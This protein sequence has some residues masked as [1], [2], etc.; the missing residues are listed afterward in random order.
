[1]ITLEM[2]ISSSIGLAHT[3]VGDLE[4]ATVLQLMDV[5]RE[6]PKTRYVT[7]PHALPCPYLDSLWIGSRHRQLRLSIEWGTSRCPHMSRDHE[8]DPS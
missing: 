2:W 6:G 5:L 7:L 3:G 8:V 1:M 4:A